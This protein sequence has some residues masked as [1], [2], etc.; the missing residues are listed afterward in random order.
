MRH[1]AR[2]CEDVLERLPLYVGGD[3][4]GPEQDGIA[5]HLA[6]CA[7]CAEEAAAASL[8]RVA[9]VEALAAEK[10]ER[11]ELWPGIRERMLAEGLLREPAPVLSGPG[12]ALSDPGR[13]LS[14]PGRALSDPGRAPSDPGGVDR[15][16]T[17][18]RI[19]R[20]AGMLAAAAVIIF[21]AVLEDPLGFFEDGNSPTPPPIDSPVVVELTPAE[22]PGRLER[23]DDEDERRLMEAEGLSPASPGPGTSGPAPMRAGRPSLA[24]DLGYR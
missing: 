18:L 4:D 21:L 5:A 12:S 17:R 2:R 19:V 7:S 3:L 13:A 10:G 6:L 8:A 9:F 20:M 16:P 24:G 15:K 23:I 11:A 14:D 22:G 1:E